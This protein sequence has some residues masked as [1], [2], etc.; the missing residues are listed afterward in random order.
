MTH[1]AISVPILIRNEAQAKGVRWN[2]RHLDTLNLPV[3]VGWTDY[4]LTK[5]FRDEMEPNLSNV[6]WVEVPQSDI[7]KDAGGTAVLRRKFNDTMAATVDRFEPEWV[8]LV[9]AN[10]IITAPFWHW[11]K[12]MMFDYPTIVGLD[13]NT[14]LLMTD[15]SRYCKLLLK[16]RNQYDISPGVNALNRS[17]WYGCNGEPYQ[18]PNCEMGLERFADDCNWVKAV[19]DYGTLISVKTG[20]DLNGYDSVHFMHDKQTMSDFDKWLINKHINNER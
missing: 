18:R 5:K 7:V 1:I 9:G 3:V 12:G 20:A 4:G 15:G 8:C 14:P 10:D 6:T 11:L 19:S 16:Y 17:A 13:I 2:L